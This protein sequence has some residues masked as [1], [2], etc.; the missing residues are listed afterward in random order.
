MRVNVFAN[1]KFG[2]SNKNSFSYKT[3][4]VPFF[5][6]IIVLVVQTKLKRLKQT[7]KICFKDGLLTFYSKTKRA[8]CLHDIVF[9]KN[10][11]ITLRCVSLHMIMGYGHT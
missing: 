9:D 6:R 11:E 8:K 4:V 7:G 1:N 3:N 10:E 5:S 2:F